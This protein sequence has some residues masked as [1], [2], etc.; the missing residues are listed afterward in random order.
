MSDTKRARRIAE[1]IATI[2]GT[3]RWKFGKHAHTDLVVEISSIIARQF[4][5]IRDEEKRERE[6]AVRNATAAE[7]FRIVALVR[8]NAKAW[9]RRKF[10]APTA[11]NKARAAILEEI[12]EAI[13]A[14]EPTEKPERIE[15]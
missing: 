13:D 6:A 12:A 14:P 11:R 7:K 8:Y 5:T 2:A 10:M 15:T 1:A 4:A 9:R 3:F